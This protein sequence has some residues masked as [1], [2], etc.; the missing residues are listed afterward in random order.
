MIRSHIALRARRVTGAANERLDA[1]NGISTV[2]TGQS[3]RCRAERHAT[4]DRGA[5]TDSAGMQ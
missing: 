3:A 4:Y 1:V 2:T 5:E